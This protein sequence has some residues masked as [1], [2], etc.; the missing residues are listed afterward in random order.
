MKMRTRHLLLPLLAPLG[1]FTIPSH[2]QVAPVSCA[3]RSIATIEALANHDHDG[4]RRYLDAVLQSNSQ[5]MEPMWDAMIEQNWGPYRS[6]G[7]PEEIANGDHTTTVRLPLTF[8]HGATTSTL[9]CD[10]KAGGAIV[11]FSLL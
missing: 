2:A 9:T 4:A 1:A 7:V 3:A 6:H 5:Q 10:P 8:D 11:E